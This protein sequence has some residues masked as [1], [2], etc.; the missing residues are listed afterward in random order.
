MDKGIPLIDYNI[1]SVASKDI[2]KIAEKITG[3]NL[4]IRNSLIDNILKIFKWR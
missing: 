1:N 2:I 4:E 3:K